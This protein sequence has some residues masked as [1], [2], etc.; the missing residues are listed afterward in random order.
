VNKM[1][2]GYCVRRKGFGQRV[3][4]RLDEAGSLTAFVAVLS[5]SLFVLVGIVVDAGR[6]IA[7]RSAA[8]TEAQ[9]A[10]RAGAGQISVDALRSG[11]IEIDP[12]AAVLAA[13]EFLASVGQL[14]TASVVG[15][16]V[17]VHI[18]ST[19]STAILGIIGINAIT[20]SVTA[21]A[22]YVHGVT[23]ED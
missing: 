14:G 8:M 4:T 17:T 5:L 13:D 1:R 9:Q 3:T 23:Q 15:Q 2:R 20:V 12:G 7:A 6:A 22:T 11:Q 19:E 16:T 18:A 21:S 10:A